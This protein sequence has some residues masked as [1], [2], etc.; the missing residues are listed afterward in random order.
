MIEQQWDEF[1]K[2]HADVQKLCPEHKFLVKQAFHGGCVSTTNAVMKSFNAKD[3]QKLGEFL[4]ALG[5]ESVAIANWYTENA[6]VQ[7]AA[8]EEK[9]KELLRQNGGI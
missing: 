2:A 8:A 4:L 5:S 7:L 1:E 3:L 9:L 6:R